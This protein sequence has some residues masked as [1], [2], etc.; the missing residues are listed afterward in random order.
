M[1]MQQNEQQN[2]YLARRLLAVTGADR[3]TLLQKLVSQDLSTLGPDQPV[4]YSLLL[5]PQGKYMFDFFVLHGENALY[6]DVPA[7]QADSL[8]ATLQKYKL[9][10]DVAFAT[11]PHQLQLR[12]ARVKE[13][14]L[15]VADPRRAGPHAGLGYRIWAEGPAGCDAGYAQKLT[16]A[17]VVEPWLEMISGT[18]MPLEFGLQH[19]NAISFTKGCYLGQ[20]LTARMQHRDLAKHMIVAAKIQENQQLPDDIGGATLSANGVTIGRVLRGAAPYVLAQ[21]MRAHASDEP[22]MLTTPTGAHMPLARCS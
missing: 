11:L 18:S 7:Q 3:L 6:L 2:Q 13:A 10:S 1:K 15:C 16:A 4:A 21:V 12:D 20:E 22:L 19:N 17:G 14:F 8:L 5:T 9:R